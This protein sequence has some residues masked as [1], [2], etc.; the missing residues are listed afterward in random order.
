MSGF[1]WLVGAGC[2]KKEWITLE[3]YRVLSEAEVVVYDDLL[4]E[5]LLELARS[6][7]ELHYVGKRLGRHSRPQEETN[8]LLIRLA[9]EGKTVC[10]LKGGDPLVFGRGGEE[11]L[12]LRDAGVP[13]AFVPGVSSALAIPE[14]HGIPLTHRNLSRSFH[15]ITAHTATGGDSLPEHLPELV[16]AGGSLVFLMGLSKIERLAEGLCA[17]GLCADTPAAVLGSTAVRGTLADIAVKAA[18]FPPPGIFVVGET[19]GLDL[20]SEPGPL[21]GRRIGLTG[22]VSF[23]ARLSRG[24]AA[25]GAEV[26]PLQESVVTR[27][28]TPGELCL[29]LD[30]KPEW[31]AFS[32]PNGVEIFF[33]LLEEAGRDVRSL[34]TLHFAAVGEG[35]ARVL[36]KH[37][38]L[39]D[40][41]PE[42]HDTPSLGAALAKLATGEVLLAGASNASKAPE[43]ALTAAG[44]AWNRL[45]LYALKPSELRKAAAVDYLLFG[46]AGGVENY[47]GLGGVQPRRAAI[48]IGEYTAQRAEARGAPLVVRAKDAST[49][50]MVQAL[51]DCEKEWKE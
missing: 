7:A 43:E 35:T 11:A 37:G 30:R 28:C 50:E 18:G 6:D 42:Q 34:G 27:C 15:V 36:R 23:Q 22:T 48:C 46:S 14:L 1:V 17:A 20:R 47:Y 13:Y 26:I 45:S 29:A 10:R 40:L 39:C 24:L 16:L 9:R 3:G 8:A 44:V 5:G 33:N 41:V 19:A 49:E 21:N 31:I 51:L 2:Q 4:A 12:A 32:S 38:I 25:T